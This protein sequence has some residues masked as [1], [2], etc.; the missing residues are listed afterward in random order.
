M[1]KHVGYVRV[2]SQD[3]NTARQLEGVQ[4]DRVFEEKASGKDTARPQLRACLDYLRDGDTLHVHSIDRLARNLGDLLRVLED[5]KARD[6][7]VQFHKESLT[8][9][10]KADPF[11]DLQLQV[12]GAVAQFERALIRERQR[13]GIAAAKAQGKRMGRAKA[14]TPGQVE[15]IKGRIA[16]GESKKALAA[17]FG[18]SRQTL[19]NALAI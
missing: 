5:L 3:Q 6:V 7:A 19:Y 14:L 9:T 12:I 11:Q 15:A 13:E 17:E 2:S 8:F 16:A 10:G 1:G 4:L 18:V